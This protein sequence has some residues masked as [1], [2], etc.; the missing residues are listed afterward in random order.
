[1]GESV[2]ENGLLNTVKAMGSGII[3]GITTTVRDDLVNGT[4]KSRGEIAGD[5]AT[6]ILEFVIGSKLLKDVITKNA[7]PDADDVVEGGT[8]T[9]RST[10]RQSELDPAKDLPQKYKEGL[11]RGAVSLRFIQNRIYIFR[12]KSEFTGNLFRGDALAF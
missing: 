7:V 11:L 2:S 10:W 6:F 5:C 4:A 1:M 12:R 8:E 9:S 3:D